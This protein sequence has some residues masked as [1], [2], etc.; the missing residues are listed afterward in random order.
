MKRERMQTENKKADTAVL[1]L[2]PSKN[3]KRSI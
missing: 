3:I 2:I 1:K